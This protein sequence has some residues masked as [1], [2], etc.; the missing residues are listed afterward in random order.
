MPL[1]IFSGAFFA[2]CL[3]RRRTLSLR[4]IFFRFLL[5][6]PL[7]QVILADKRRGNKTWMHKSL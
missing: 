5:T 3:F 1:K 7:F 2:S 4:G 6:N